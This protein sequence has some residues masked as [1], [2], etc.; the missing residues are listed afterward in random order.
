MIEKLILLPVMVILLTAS[1]AQH[2]YVINYKELTKYPKQAKEPAY[3]SFAR[4]LNGDT[5]KGSDLKKEHN[6]LNGKTNGP[7]MA[8]KLT[9]IALLLTKMKTVSE[10]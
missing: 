5:L 6:Y 2:V 8:G 7:W 1:N 9:S 4:Y 3:E 10:S